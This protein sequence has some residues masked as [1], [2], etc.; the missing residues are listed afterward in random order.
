MVLTKD[1]VIGTALRLDDNG[2]YIRDAG[3]WSCSPEY[4]NNGDLRSEK[5]PIKSISQKFLI[6][7]S[8][9]EWKKDNA[10]YV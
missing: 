6:E 7:I 5:H 3:A 8:E 4:D 2:E 9:E 10:G 1:A